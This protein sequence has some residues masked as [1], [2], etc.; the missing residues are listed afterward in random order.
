[1][2][3]VE[4]WMLKILQ[5]FD[6]AGPTVAVCS[7]RFYS[8]I[9]VNVFGPEADVADGANVARHLMNT[10]VEATADIP[11]HKLV[12]SGYDFPVCEIASLIGCQMALDGLLET[13]GVR[14]IAVNSRLVCLKHE[15]EIV[16]PVSQDI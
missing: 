15:P 13:L 14:V 6:Q 16:A 2:Q 4:T 9:V 8:P 7:V 5:V 11:P 1:M 3:M 10:F 12:R